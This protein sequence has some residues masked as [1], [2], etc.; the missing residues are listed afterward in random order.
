VKQEDAMREIGPYRLLSRLGAGGMG[1]AYQASDPTGR[2]VVVKVLRP[3]I[4]EDPTGRRR[5]AREVDTMRRVRSP[6]VAQVVDADMLNEPPY[7][8]A[9][10]ARGP[11]VREHV[12]RTGPMRG[13]ALLRLASGLA[14]AVGAIHQAGVV[15]RDLTPGNVLLVDGEPV[16]IDFGI[17]W[18]VDSTRLTMTGVVVGT[19]GYLAAELLDG[20]D[21]GP[22][23]DV[24]AL[25]ATLAYAATGRH[26]FGSGPLPAIHFRMAMGKADLTGV[27]AP[28]LEPIR[29]ALAPDPA[30]RPTVPWLRDAFRRLDPAMLGDDGGAATGGAARGAEAGTPRVAAGPGGE[31]VGRARTERM[32]GTAAGNPSPGEDGFAAR[33]AGSATGRGGGPATGAGA[34][35]A[36][37]SEAE[38]ATGSEAGREARGAAGRQ[39]G[40]AAGVAPAEARPPAR[41]GT[42][43]AIPVLVAALTVALAALPAWVWGPWG[44]VGGG[45]FTWLRVGYSGPSD[46]RSLAVRVGAEVVTAAGAATAAAWGLAVLMWLVRG[47]V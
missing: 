5:L 38:G 24:F 37:G 28:L 34:A 33:G 19:P 31:D 14:E 29:G 26:P 16:V 4:A 9:Q 43:A 12:E 40:R 27:P 1:V 8:V 22:P 11:S 2:V 45:V 17:A 10:Y 44:L 18:A 35:G 39:T 32:P 42:T 46:P 15:H 21:M 47:H 23:V 6:Y 36:A 30:Y 7:L 20:S 3:E 25:G 41:V 13:A